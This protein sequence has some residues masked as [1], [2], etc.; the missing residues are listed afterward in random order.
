MYGLIIGK[1][2]ST[3]KEMLGNVISYYEK[4]NIP[5]AV[6]RKDR[7]VFKN[8]DY[9]VVVSQNHPA[10]IRGYKPKILYL[11]CNVDD[12]EMLNNIRYLESFNIKTYIW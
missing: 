1:N 9:W 3:A 6:L 12:E 5:I 2:F 8:H 11:D 10:K 4:N 7:V